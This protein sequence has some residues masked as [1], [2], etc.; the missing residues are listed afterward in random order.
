MSPVKFTVRASGFISALA[1]FVIASE[2]SLLRGAL[3]IDKIE[4]E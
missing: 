1:L 3:F 2:L 4:K